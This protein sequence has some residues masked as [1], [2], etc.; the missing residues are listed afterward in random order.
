MKKNYINTKYIWLL[1][2]LIGFTACESD[3]DSSMSTAPLPALTSGSADFS[4]YVSIGNS[5]TAGF[6]DNALFMASQMNSLPS[7]LAARF[8]N[9]GGGSFTQPMM[10]DNFGGIAVGGNRILDPR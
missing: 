9:A 10:N 2:I 8:S 1:A 7:I 4:N 5:L 3:D 6:T